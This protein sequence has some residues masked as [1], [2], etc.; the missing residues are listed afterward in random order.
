VDASKTGPLQFNLQHRDS[1]SAAH[2]PP[3]ATS[4]LYLNFNQLLSYQWPCRVIS[5]Q[6]LQTRQ[7]RLGLP[8]KLRWQLPCT[9]RVLYSIINCSFSSKLLRMSMNQVLSTSVLA[10]GLCPLFQW[11]RILFNHATLRKDGHLSWVQR[12]GLSTCDTVGS[13]K[14][15]SQA[16]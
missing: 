9:T 5:V 3:P 4:N 10:R 2:Q 6:R 11:T 7:N 1:F 15:L 14:S 13:L 8:V 16:E 12:M